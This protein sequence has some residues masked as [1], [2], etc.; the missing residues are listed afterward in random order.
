MRSGLLPSGAIPIENVHSRTL[1]GVQV[2]PVDLTGFLDRPPLLER[3]KSA[4]FPVREDL[5]Y[6]VINSRKD[7]TAGVG[8]TLDMSS[9]GIR[10]STRERIEIGR[11]AEVSV[12]WPA[13][14]GGTC[15][16]KVV[17]CGRVV[18]SDVDWAALSIQRY[19]FRTRGSGVAHAAPGCAA[20]F[21]SVTRQSRAAE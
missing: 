2:S 12:N 16:L 4:R 15:P 1:R 9:R 5:H 13:R 21:P 3:R 20:P 8:L 18:R 14:L 19:E 6:R 7:N 11:Y 10:F 17:A